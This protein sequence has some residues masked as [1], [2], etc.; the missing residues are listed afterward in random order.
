MEQVIEVNYNYSSA[1]N[2][3]NKLLDKNIT[4]N[5]ETDWKTI[6]SN[7]VEYTNLYDYFDVEHSITDKIINTSIVLRNIHIQRGSFS[8][9]DNPINDPIND[10]IFKLLLWLLK[11]IDS[12]DKK[13]YIKYMNIYFKLH[14]NCINDIYYGILKYSDDRNF[15]IKTKI[16]AK[17]SSYDDY[18]IQSIY[19]ILN[20]LDF[21]CGNIFVNTQDYINNVTSL[22][23]RIKSNEILITK[24]QSKLNEYDKL[25]NIKDDYESILID[26][27]RQYNKVINKLHIE[28]SKQIDYLNHK[29]SEQIEKYKY[30]AQ[31]LIEQY[32]DKE[33]ILINKYKNKK[34]KLH[35]EL[36]K[37]NNIIIAKADK[38]KFLNE[39]ISDLK[40][41]YSSLVSE[42]KHINNELKTAT[43]ISKAL[44]RSILDLRTEN[45][46]LDKQVIN[47]NDKLNTT[48]QDYI[49]RLNNLKKSKDIKINQLTEEL[50]YL[51]IQLSDITNNQQT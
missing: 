36:D 17:K 27:N 30:E 50:K 5:V 6:K 45:N 32:S 11:S 3:A 14:L 10:N 34:D 22:N 24:L 1:N 18:L 48:E 23:Y 2:N 33:K 20:N 39:T 19:S 15:N 38:I 37:L 43:N 31:Q 25:K 9:L 51:T 4:Y 35:N 41:R 29:H 42:N 21:Y 12:Y 49:T 8:L 46:Q 44:E 47:L 28:Y 26:Y 16:S 13:I 40:K 7:K